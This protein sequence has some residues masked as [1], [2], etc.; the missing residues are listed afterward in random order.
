MS[1]E[2]QEPQC[3]SSAD[4][5][6]AVLRLGN[7]DGAVRTE[8][9]RVVK[10]SGVEAIEPL[11]TV[12]HRELAIYRMRR[13]TG[14]AVFLA[15]LVCFYA[16]IHSIRDVYMAILVFAGFLSGMFFWLFMMTPSRLQKQTTAVLSQIDDLR[17][18]APLTDVVHT[19]YNV[20]GEPVKA[21]LIP[22][23]QRLRASDTSL[24]AERQHVHFRTVLKYWDNY[25]LGPAYGTHYIV[26]VLNAL[27][28]VGELQDLPFVE[29]IAYAD[30]TR[31]AAD[32]GLHWL[33]KGYNAFQDFN[34]GRRMGTLDKPRIV[35]AAQECLPYLQMNAEQQRVSNSLL[36]ASDSGTGKS[37]ALL[38]PATGRES[39]EPQTLLRA[40]SGGVEDDQ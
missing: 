38:R 4:L 34:N 9:E 31:R 36:R 32:A 5:E 22:L 37:N 6:R 8:A 10:Q 11:A 17:A 28:Q 25:R 35:Q 1:E 33:R 3:Q 30:R 19:S 15:S 14:S 13:R 23:L 18:I 2:A 39:L 12:L 26:A 20:G 24:I 7:R 27:Q 29:H 16:L 40:V 21:V